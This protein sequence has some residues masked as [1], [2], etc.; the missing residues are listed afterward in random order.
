[1]H[2]KLTSVSMDPEPQFVPSPL[3]RLS[4]CFKHHH[5]LLFESLSKLLNFFKI[6]KGQGCQPML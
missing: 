1:M 2:K 4:Y 3:E 5:I 6:H